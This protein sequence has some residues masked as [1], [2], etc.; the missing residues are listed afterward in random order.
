MSIRAKLILS[1]IAMILTPVVLSLAAAV[2]IFIVSAVSFQ[3]RY[4]LSP[5]FLG[6]I[7]KAIIEVCT[8]VEHASINNPEKFKDR[9][10]M[11]EVEQKLD[12]I[13]LGV[14]IV[15]NERVVYASQELKSY[16]I[17]KV[18]EGDSDNSYQF[19]ALDSKNTTTIVKQYDFAS[20]NRK[21]GSAYLVADI[22]PIYEFIGGY[23]DLIINTVILIFAATSIFL[24]WILSRGILKPLNALKLSAEEIKKGNLDYEVKCESKDELGR[25]CS[26]FNDMR[27]EL[28]ESYKIQQKYEE[29]RK[30]LLSSISHDLKTPITSIKGYIEGIID[31]V[32]NTPDKLER[33]AKTI[34]K[35]TMDMD[36]LIDDLF[37][38]SKLDMKKL[39]FDF[40][41]VDLKRYFEDCV[42]ELRQDLEEENSE[43]SLISTLKESSYVLADR[44]KLK[45]VILNIVGNSIKYKGKDRLKLEIYLSSDEEYAYV[46][47]KD[48]GKGISES[49]LTRIFE[50]FYRADTSRNTEQSGSGLG[51]SIARQIIEEH[52]G[53][54]WAESTIDKGTSIYFTLKLYYGRDGDYYEKNTD[55]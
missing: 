13:K 31:G 37:L 27:I 21:P 5:D 48:S 8:E 1:Y 19:E 14:V 34:Y 46:Q 4:D 6:D 53:R 32:A 11:R 50:R 39:N 28:K 24:V 45:R 15:E 49:E 23:V 20:N 7:P 16:V 25:L 42:E 36:R 17:E 40:E 22:S 9:Q 29:D 35:K 43:I 12:I 55:N 38:Y 44:E 54:I 2:I 26:T 51:L 30:A 47:I 3:S 33:Y 10:F 41:N 18:L 52:G